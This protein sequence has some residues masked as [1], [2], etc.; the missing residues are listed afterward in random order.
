VGVFELAEA[1]LGLGLGAVAGDH[2]GDRPVV[3]VGHQHAFA[4]DL[5][6]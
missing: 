4:E 3:A 5:F 1:E 6:F 2:V